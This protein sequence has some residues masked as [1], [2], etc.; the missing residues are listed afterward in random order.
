MVA[1]LL[2]MR[3][4]TPQDTPAG[5]VCEYVYD[6]GFG[7]GLVFA[8]C[9]YRDNHT[10]GAPLSMCVCMYVWTYVR[11]DVWMYIYIYIYIYVYAY[12]CIYITCTYTYI[13]A[14]TYTYK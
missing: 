1:G 9:H 12:I 7:S 3:L 14:Y 6:A 4:S 11:M 8:V 10:V 2:Q 13:G 5:K